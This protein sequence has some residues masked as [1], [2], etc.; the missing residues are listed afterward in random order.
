[1][2]NVGNEADDQ[3]RRGDFGVEGFFVFEIEAEGGGPRV[4]AGQGGR[5]GFF[6]IADP[7]ADVGT[8][9]EIP[10]EGSGDETGTENENGFNGSSPC[11]ER[12][13]GTSADNDSRASVG[14]DA[15]SWLF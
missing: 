15:G 7:D 1:M 14:R 4:A 10:D 9:E 12:N 6:E 2:E 13:R 8:L 11:R 5:L 3:V